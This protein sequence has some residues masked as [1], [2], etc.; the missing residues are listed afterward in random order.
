ML[1]DDRTGWD[2]RFCREKLKQQSLTGWRRQF[3]GFFPSVHFDVRTASIHFENQSP[4]SPPFRWLGHYSAR[5]GACQRASQGY[6]PNR[7][8]VG[9][10]GVAII[11]R[12]AGLCDLHVGRAVSTQISVRPLADYSALASGRCTCFRRSS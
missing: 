4:L 8:C 11:S 1:E 12:W 9:K 3:F 10:N 7:S 2:C 6:G 5:N